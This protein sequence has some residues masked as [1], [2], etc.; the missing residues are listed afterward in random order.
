MKDKIA[1][2]VYKRTRI[3]KTEE[4]N[5]AQ[6]EYLVNGLRHWDVMHAAKGDGTLS[7]REIVRALG[8]D[9]L[10]LGLKPQ[11]VRELVDYLD[12]ET[13]EGSIPY[14]KFVKMIEIGDHAPDYNPFFDA[15]DKEIVGLKKLLAAPWQWEA[16]DELIAKSKELQGYS[17]PVKRASTAYTGRRRRTLGPETAGY[18]R[19]LCTSRALNRYHDTMSRERASTVAAKEALVHCD[20][21]QGVFADMRRTSTAKMSDIC[22]RFVPPQPTDWTRTG[23]GGDGV[24]SG[25]G[26]YM[27]PTSRFNTTSGAYFTPLLYEPN[28]PVRRD[29]V[30]DSTREFQ[31][32]QVVKDARKARSRRQRDIYAETRLFE[33]QTRFMNEESKVRDKAQATLD[34]FKTTYERD[35]FATRCEAPESMQRRSNRPLYDRMW[36]GSQNNMLHSV[37]KQAKYATP[38]TESLRTAPLVQH[39]KATRSRDV[40]GDAARNA[41]RRFSISVSNAISV[42]AP[43]SRPHTP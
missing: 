10:N 8:P 31:Q 30:A 9:H 40:A 27:E 38:T 22:P 34:Y 13:S 41:A 3:T 21:S 18:G 2:A 20:D 42:A 16:T 5:L 39:L 17:S 28:K 25:S 36:G 29:S 33:E 24:S 37:N 23:L 26:L 15:R 43:S 11:E 7:P 32:K 1:D 35:I 6:D 19:P 14:K 12:L 4:G